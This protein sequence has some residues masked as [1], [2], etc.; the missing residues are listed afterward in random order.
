MCPPK[1]P[2]FLI[3]KNSV[4]IQL[5]L[6]NFSTPYL[7]N[8]MI[9][10]ILTY[11]R[12]LTSAS[13]K[14]AHFS[15]PFGKVQISYFSTI[16]DS[17][18]DWLKYLYNIRWFKTL[19][20]ATVLAST[21]ANIHCDLFVRVATEP[22]WDID[23][24]P[25]EHRGL[26]DRTVAQQNSVLNTYICALRKLVLLSLKTDEFEY[27]TRQVKITGPPSAKLLTM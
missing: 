3:V 16:F 2:S 15:L 27:Y 18:I 11:R 9:H 20:S 26:T 23:W 14:F 4:K 5:I 24:I 25:A 12:N 10:N 13:Y 19:N 22:G 21:T 1:S 8:M 17:K 7:G 6:I